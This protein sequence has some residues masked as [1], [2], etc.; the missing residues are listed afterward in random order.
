MSGPCGARGGRRRE[1]PRSS[2][3]HLVVGDERMAPPDDLD[4][5]SDMDHSGVGVV[6][7]HAEADVVAEAA[8][9]SERP[10]GL[11]SL[12]H[13]RSRLLVGA[14]HDATP[15]SLHAVEHDIADS[16]LLPGFFLEPVFAALDDDIRPE[17]IHRHL[18]LLLVCEADVEAAQ[19]LHAREKEREAIREAG[20]H[21]LR[22]L[23]TLTAR[24]ALRRVRHVDEP[25]AP[26]EHHAQA[27]V[28]P[29]LT[30][31]DAVGH[32]RVAPDRD[33]HR[34]GTTGEVEG[35][36]HSNRA[37]VAARPLLPSEGTEEQ[38][39]RV[40]ENLVANRYGCELGALTLG[41]EPSVLVD[42]HEAA[43]SAKAGHID[44]ADRE[45]IAPHP[46][47]GVLKK[48][49]NLDP[50][51]PNLRVGCETLLK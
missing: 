33:D 44:R 15:A 30:V 2:D 13:A 3:G 12:V 51:H 40:A 9:L 36:N 18:V 41:D 17:P 29:V 37:V 47:Y 31:V 11:T 34:V 35:G 24:E 38:M 1:D 28:D 46:L 32:Y 7:V 42:H 22:I 26:L 8:V 4:L 21:S 43:I 16:E 19:R 27:I 39:R 10:Q 45:A 23:V 6:E 48:T 25:D 5:V 49:D 14:G 20:E 50:G